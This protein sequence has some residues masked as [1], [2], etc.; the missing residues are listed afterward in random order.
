MNRGKKL[1]V[2]FTSIFAISAATLFA[3]NDAQ[4]GSVSDPL[5]TKS[6]VDQKIDE[7]INLMGSLIEGNDNGVNS[8]NDTSNTAGSMT[9]EAI[10]PIA[11]GTFIL[12]GE[13]TEIILRGGSALAVCP[14]VN[15]LSNLTAGADIANGQEV[16]LN[17]LIVI[18]RKDGRGI[19][20]ENDAYIMVRGEITYD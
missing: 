5:V 12:G 20:I 13:G 19:L 15:G 1:L 16:P 18:P 17:N 9:Y 14:G 8:D 2:T 4:P 7:V 10:G 11:A 3:A 6:Y